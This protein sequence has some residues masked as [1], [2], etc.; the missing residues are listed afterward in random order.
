MQVLNV[1]V[2]GNLNLKNDPSSTTRL[3]PAFRLGRRSRLPVWGPRR[4]AAA[5]T[6]VTVTGHGE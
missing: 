2:P 5:L 6:T 1:T 4:R 3:G